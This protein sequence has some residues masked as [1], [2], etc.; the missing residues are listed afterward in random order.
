MN[1]PYE[2]TQQ[3][4]DAV[5][6]LEGPLRYKHFIGR[7]A[8]TQVLFTLRTDDGWVSAVDA[9]GAAGLPLWPHPAYALEAA[10]GE[11]EGSELAEIDVYQFAD[12]WL[13]AMAAGGMNAIV[14]PTPAAHGVLVAATELQEDLREELA[15][16]D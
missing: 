7:V 16:Y 11:W 2:L 12:D 1:T 8:D 3:E 15:R 9:N 14:F 5:T 6:C 4:H 10:T 13:P